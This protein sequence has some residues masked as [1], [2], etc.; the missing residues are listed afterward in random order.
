MISRL[1]SPKSIGLTNKKAIHE[2]T[3][4]IV[5]DF[6]NFHRKGFADHCFLNNFY[7]LLFQML[8]S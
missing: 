4:I 3:A 7:N 2:K 1:R 5:E 6:R 8:D